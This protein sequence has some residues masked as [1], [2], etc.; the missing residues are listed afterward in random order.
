MTL[1]SLVENFDCESMRKKYRSGVAKMRNA[2]KEAENSKVLKELLE[3]A[4]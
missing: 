4:V 2:I 1:E 3:M